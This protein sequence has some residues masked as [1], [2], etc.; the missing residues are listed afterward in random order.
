VIA[1]L[2]SLPAMLAL[3]RNGV[4]ATIA[5]AGVARTAQPPILARR[6]VRP[7]IERPVCL[8]IP[9]AVPQSA[10]S[11][12][13]EETIRTLARETAALWDKIS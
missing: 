7:S 8:C 1:D 3:A 9:T 2:D 4:A 12:A 6:L 13:T 5:S 11:L 10:A